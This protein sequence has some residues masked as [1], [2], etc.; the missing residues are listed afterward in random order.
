MMGE[1]LRWVYAALA[2][3]AGIFFYLTLFVYMGTTPES[4]SKPLTKANYLIPAKAL[5]CWLDEPMEE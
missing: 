5:A 3:Y 1:F 4:C 2:I